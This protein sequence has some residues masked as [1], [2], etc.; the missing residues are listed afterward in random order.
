[1]KGEHKEDET[2]VSRKPLLPVPTKILVDHEKGPEDATYHKEE[3]E[4]PGDVEAGENGDGA[5]FE[6]LLHRGWLPFRGQT[7]QIPWPLRRGSRKRRE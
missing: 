6:S 1:M 5:L 4:G 2:M 3:L 7:T